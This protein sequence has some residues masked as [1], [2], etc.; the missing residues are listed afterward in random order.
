METSP[1][2]RH[3]AAR[4]ATPP[5][6][7]DTAAMPDLPADAATPDRDTAGPADGPAVPPEHP[8]AP[9]TEPAAAP[10]AAQSPA[11]DRRDVADPS[12]TPG[13]APSPAGDD[14][15]SPD[16]SST[17]GAAQS[18]AGGGGDTGDGSSTA[19]RARHPTTP[20]RATEPLATPEPAKTSTGRR[21][22]VPPAIPEA[23]GL[24]RPGLFRRARRDPGGPD[25]T[26]GSVPREPGRG[27]R[28]PRHAAA[29]R[30][31]AVPPL[32]RP[33]EPPTP[34]REAA[35]LTQP[36][37][38]DLDGSGDPPERPTRRRAILVALAV[39]AAASAAAL[40]AGLL[41]W[42]PEP[43]RDP[44]RRL[45][46][47]EVERLSAMRVT[48]QRDVRAG[49]RVS[50]GTG[51]ARSELVGWVDWARPLVYLDVGG[52]G[53]GAERGLVQATASTVVLR[54]DPAAAPTPTPPPLVPP[55]DRWRLREPPATGAVAPVRDLLL[56]LGANRIDVVSTRARWQG[57][58]S[59][60]GT[61]VDILET[62]L[63]ADPAPTAPRAAPARLWLDGDARLHRLEGRLPDG[64][65]VTVELERT[66]RPTLR[67][68]A[69]LGGHPG[70]PRAL[71]DAE[72]DRLARLP[73]R[74]RALGGA[75]VTL[76]APLGPTAN[77]RAAGWLRWTESA[78][79]LAVDEA[80]SPGRRTLLRWR[81]G[82]ATRAEVP[83]GPAGDVPATP[84]LPPPAG[85]T[86]TAARPPADD[87]DRLLAAALR[88]D[89]APV[90]ARSAVRLRGDR[91]ADRSVDV[92][93]VRTG[94]A[95]LRYWVDRDGLLRRLE[96]R[97]GR[98][99]WAQL[100]LSPGR[101]PAL[102]G[103][104]AAPRPRRR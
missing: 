78:A 102:P 70:L 69:A 18:P 58:A 41:Q 75:T 52:P 13:T 76:T 51:A 65:P 63:P 19:D 3:A 1:R 25:G 99:V 103:G 53:A 100:D 42:S 43:A 38:P 2:R 82:R 81:G 35:A 12:S 54:P 55:A 34:G 83:A 77:L 10:D 45:T 22:A 29:A 87:L 93:E 20:R 50:V 91:T 36:E 94:G 14:R 60:D 79:Y 96:L 72:A 32:H 27:H 90:P 74:L 64:R 92:I 97:T 95:V 16:P 61:A 68:V 56:G 59:T 5:P 8:T 33:A 7:A 6:T 28:R 66:D 57:R 21:A 39:T 46:H 4:D 98:G 17:S 31:P 11:G 37:E 85:L 15:H 40:V 26:A 73:A 80:D 30:P 67:P 89:D 101:V 104:P 88:G 86:W 62:T 84:P 9:T 47:G 48:N 44:A 49:V 24:S 71:T 23:T